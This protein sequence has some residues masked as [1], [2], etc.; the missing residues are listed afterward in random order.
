MPQAK[1]TFL[2]STLLLLS[3]AHL[4]TDLSQGALPALLPELQKA[5]NLTY[6]QIGFMVL[7]QNMASSVIQP[8]FGYLSDRIALPWLIPAGVIISGLG[9]ASLVFAD[10]YSSLLAAVTI[11][12]LGI[13][14][15][16]PQGSKAAHLTSAKESKGHSMGIFSVGGNLGFALG[17]MYITFLLHL[18]GGL[19]NIVWFGLPA[20]ILAPILWSQL[21][22]IVPAAPAASLHAAAEESQ[23]RRPIPWGLLTVLL[24]YIFIRSSI[25]T[26]LS[27]YI[28]LYYVNFLSGS[29][30][31]ASNLLS[32]FFLSG[33][34]GTY[35]GG[36]LSDK[37]GRK[38]IIIVSMAATLPLVAMLPY[39]GGIATVIL[40]GLIG[41]VMVSSFSTT[42]VMAQEA[43]PSHIGM[44]GGLTIGFSIGL[45]G[46]GATL[47][48][49]VADRF[50]IPAV[51]TLLALLPLAGL[52]C[53]LFLPGSAG[54]RKE[55]KIIVSGKGV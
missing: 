30:F 26:G 46:V 47:L 20:L 5:Y 28:P 44:A 19:A 38:T 12:G 39:T 25:H 21:R 54:R 3:L 14:A 55:T 2:P 51:F 37:W 52:L 13:A 16:H 1:A 27:T 45:G 22:R 41:F 11:G 7:M 4:V 29:A 23:T 18:S 50:G 15:F 35:A 31:Y 32:V 33:V 49:H 9:M 8:V 42:I 10:S 36:R 53:T 17:A 6:A 43:M 48:G 24:T 34:I 40:V